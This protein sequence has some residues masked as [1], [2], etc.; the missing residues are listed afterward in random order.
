[1]PTT[2]PHLARLNMKL[3]QRRLYFEVWLDLA[4]YGDPTELRP[5]STVGPLISDLKRIWADWEERALTDVMAKR[6]QTSAWIQG[7]MALPGDENLPWHADNAEHASDEGVDVGVE[8]HESDP[9]VDAGCAEQPTSPAQDAIQDPVTG[10]TETVPCTNDAVLNETG[11][12]RR[13]SSV[14]TPASV[15]RSSAAWIRN[16][17]LRMRRGPSTKTAPVPSSKSSR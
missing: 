9:V 12:K 1:M 13:S 3:R 16:N 14:I 4:A 17:V 2:S 6:P 10:L 7:I 8:A 5:P 11:T 15:L